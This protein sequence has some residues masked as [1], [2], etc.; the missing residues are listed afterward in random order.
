MSV[1]KLEMFN[2]VLS[3]SR[4][5]HSVASEL[6]RI[7]INNYLKQKAIGLGAVEPPHEISSTPTMA[8]SSVG[9]LVSK[10]G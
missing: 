4:S 9:R 2:A 7:S 10:A 5:S 6:Q 1:T 8:E 3:L